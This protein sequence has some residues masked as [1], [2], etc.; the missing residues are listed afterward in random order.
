[1]TIRDYLVTQRPPSISRLCGLAAGCAI[2][3]GCA[4]A[5]VPPPEWAP[6]PQPP[7]PFSVTSLRVEDG[8][9]AMQLASAVQQAAA[10]HQVPYVELTS[11]WCRACHWLDRGLSDSA[12]MRAFGGTYLVRVD[13]DAWAGRLEGTGLDYHSG[14]LPAFVALSE[15][16]RPV[17]YWADAGVWQS[18]VP[19]E[20]APVLAA[21]FHEER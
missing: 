5:W 17:G 19:R 7:A 3:A 21:F 15:R 1:V 16:G 12:L 8:S 11:R 9:L 20:A 14:P 2:V 18:D 10:A 13:V 4:G 6:K